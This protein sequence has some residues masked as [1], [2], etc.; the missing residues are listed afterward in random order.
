MSESI[1]LSELLLRFRD[2]VS[3]N[4]KQVA[5]A[6]EIPPPS[7]SFYENGERIPPFKILI[8]LLQ[9]YDAR[10]NI[11]TDLGKWVFEVEDDEVIL[12]E[13]PKSEELGL[14]S[15]LDDQEKEDLISYIRRRRR[16]AEED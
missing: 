6:V 3:Q 8:K 10:L 16:H 12:K 7:L 13:E 11:E 4:Q 15:G 9:H 5:D 2:I 14:L 1:E